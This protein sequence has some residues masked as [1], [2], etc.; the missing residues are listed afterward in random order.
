M[1][2]LWPSVGRKGALAVL[3][4]GGA[5]SAPLLTAGG[6]TVSGDRLLGLGAVVTVTVLALRGRL[7]W[8]AV[9]SALAVFTGIQLLA[10]VLSAGSFPGGPKFSLMYVLGFGCFALMAECGRERDGVQRAAQ[11]W[12]VTGAFLGFAGAILA[13]LANILQTKLW[14]TDLSERLAFLSTVGPYASKVTFN[15]WNLYSSFLLVAFALSLWRWPSPAADGRLPRWSRFV[16]VV[17]IALGL[18]FGLT[19]AAWIAM[20]GLV[21]FWVWARRPAWQQVGHLILVVALGFVIQAAAIG[22][23]PLHYRVLRPIETGKDYNMAGRI[24]TST[25]TVKSLAGAPI[26]GHGAG[27][28]NK[29]EVY[30]PNAAPTRRDRSKLGPRKLGPPRPKPKPKAWNGNL[31]LFLL[32]DSGMVGLASFVALGAV[33]G[34]AARRTLRVT[35]DVAARAVLVSLL[36]AG[37]ALL[38]AFQFTHGLWLMYPYVYLGL[39]TAAVTNATSARQRARGPSAPPPVDL[40]RRAPQT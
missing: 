40:P 18:V 12:V 21:T 38:F 31:V 16:P 1:N 34:L 14:G 29:L 32:Q 11:I 3:I 26:L 4:V 10:S 35:D 17:G 28:S 13:V 24:A 5:C 7:H 36:A 30:D 22:A 25:A 9:H 20:A 39:V 6:V 2:A 15:E 27:S 37:V 33:V 19:R 8:T 23:S